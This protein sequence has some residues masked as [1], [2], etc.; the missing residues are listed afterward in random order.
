LEPDTAAIELANRSAINYRDLLFAGNTRVPPPAICTPRGNAELTQIAERIEKAVLKHFG[1]ETD[2]CQ[3]VSDLVFFH[4]EA[5]KYYLQLFSRYRPRIVFGVNNGSLSGLFSAAKD[6]CIPA[7]EFQ[8]GASCEHTIIWSYP[9]SIENSHPGL[10]LATAYFTFS[11]YWNDNTHFPVKMFRTVGND[12]FH[13]EPAAHV[14]ED[15]LIISSYMYRDALLN[16]A[17]ELADLDKNKKI[18]FKLHFHE[19]DQRNAVIGACAGRENIIVVDDGLDFSQLFA[20]CEHVVGVHSTVI[21]MALQAKKKICLLKISNYFW[22]EDIFEFIE[23]FDTAEELHDITHAREGV[24][25]GNA[26]DIPELF[27]RFSAQKFMRAVDDVQ[28]ANSP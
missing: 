9:K 6:Q 23:L 11:D 22:H 19:F 17:L 8:H 3:L 13:Q 7:V 10:S 21:Y 28:I 5:R 16:L 24:Y 18:Y 15:L 25:F 4:K 26:N 1:L 2:L 12:D 20:L 27:Q 14:R